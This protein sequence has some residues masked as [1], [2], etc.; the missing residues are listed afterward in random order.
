MTLEDKDMADGFNAGYVIEKHQ[1]E[2]SQRIV[3]AA[4]GVDTPFNKGFVAGA[5]EYSKERTIQSKA[6]D[7]MRDDTSLDITDLDQGIKPRERI[8]SPILRFNVTRH[9][10]FLYLCIFKGW[11]LR[12]ENINIRDTNLI[13]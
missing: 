4:K 12:T 9:E 6:I 1:P 8:K 3:K 5:E 10:T 13:P 7:L 11:V 2:L